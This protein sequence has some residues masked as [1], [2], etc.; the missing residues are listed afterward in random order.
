MK[1]REEIRHID[2]DNMNIILLGAPGSGKGTLSQHLITNYNC[3]Q[4]STGDL[5]R[6][7]IK[8][9]SEL[10][11]KIKAISA[12]GGLVDTQTVISMIENKVKQLQSD[13]KSIIFDGFPRTKEQAVYLDNLLKIDHIILLDA[14]LSLIMSRL[15]GRRSCPTCGFTTNTGT[16]ELARK[17]ICAK[18]GGQLITRTDDTV[19]TIQKRYSIYEKESKDI[20]SYY[21]SRVVTINAD[22]GGNQV[23]AIADGILR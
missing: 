12:A 17:N 13:G 4:I 14:K 3:V 5:I 23:N 16:D 18:C 6:A 7:E 8:S 11:N 19:E 9:G 21:G 15:T 22:Q 10:G 2:F 1:P 20:L